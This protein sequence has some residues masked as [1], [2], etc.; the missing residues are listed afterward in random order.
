MTLRVNPKSWNRTAEPFLRYQGSEW[1]MMPFFLPHF[2]PHRQFVSVFGGSCA[3][4]LGKP[5]SLEI[6]SE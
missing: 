4:I 5:F 3:E 2:P 6:T 1:G